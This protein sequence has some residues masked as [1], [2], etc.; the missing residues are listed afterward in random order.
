M[1]IFCTRKLNG[2]YVVESSEGDRFEFLMMVKRNATRLRRV[3]PPHWRVGPWPEDAEAITAAARHAA[4]A[5]ARHD[6]FAV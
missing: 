2:R 6:G 5:R 1:G 3:G 4:I